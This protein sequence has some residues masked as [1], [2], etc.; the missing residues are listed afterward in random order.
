ML[1]CS[2]R[3]LPKRIGTRP[4][5]IYE[6]SDKAGFDFPITQLITKQTGIMNL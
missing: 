5:K 3:N 6:T 2:L 1:S 4:K